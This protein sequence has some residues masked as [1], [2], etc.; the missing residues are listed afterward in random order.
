MQDLSVLSLVD[1]CILSEEEGVEKPNS[2]IWR[3]G[4]NALSSDL[5]LSTRMPED[6]TAIVMHVGDEIVW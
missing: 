6:Q 3:R 1:V 4:L 2:E 5:D